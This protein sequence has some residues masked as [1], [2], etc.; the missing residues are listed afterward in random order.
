MVLDKSLQKFTVLWSA[1]GKNV[2]LEAVFN[3]NKMGLTYS[4]N[5]D[6]K[7][8]KDDNVGEK[9]FTNIGDTI[10]KVELLFD[11]YRDTLT[12]IDT[13]GSRT[14]G[15]TGTAVSVTKHTDKLISL[16]R[17]N[18]SKHRPPIATLKWGSMKW[19]GSGAFECILTDLAIDYTMFLS[20]GTPV[21]AT[22]NCTFKQWRT[23]GE[24]SKIKNL[25]SPDV[26]KLHVVRRGETLS[27][28]SQLH[29]EN[30]RYWRHIARENKITNPLRLKP[31]DT[32][33]IPKLK[34]E[35]R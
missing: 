11:T 13:Q 31:G 8:K 14:T 25:E 12:T 4:A 30:P 29:F 10:L 7:G 20:D 28:I 1:G 34:P 2:E 19:Y 27:A 32:L 6:D 9:Q 35:E 23:S 3:P 24:D 26:N 16:V 15:K 5:W 33:V 22:A 21:R 17:I 18:S